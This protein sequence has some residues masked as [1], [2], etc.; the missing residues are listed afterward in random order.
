MILM[1]KY[2]DDNESTVY[3]THYQRLIIIIIIPSLIAF[4]TDGTLITACYFEKLDMVRYLVS[5]GADKVIK[6]IT[7]ISLFC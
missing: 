5:V 7:F 3:C 2:E 4:E 1:S 6:N